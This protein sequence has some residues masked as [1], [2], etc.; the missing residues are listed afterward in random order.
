[1]SSPEDWER[2]PLPPIGLAIERYVPWP[3]GLAELPGGA[4]FY[5][6]VPD[7]DGLVFLRYGD[8]ETPEAFLNSLTDAVRTHVTVDDRPVEFLGGPARRLAIMQQMPKSGCTAPRRR[9]PTHAHDPGRHDHQD[10]DHRLHGER[11][12]GPGRV[13]CRPRATG[14]APPDHR[15]HR[16]ERLTA[17]LTD[18]A[19]HGLVIPA[20]ASYWLGTRIRPSC[21]ERRGASLRPPTPPDGRAR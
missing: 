19:R 5:Q 9:A 15:S 20:S 12:A 8:R 7:S 14:R 16:G 2:Y 3:A 10:R 18:A 13:P 4:N 11:P 17:R 1:M 21:T 6:R